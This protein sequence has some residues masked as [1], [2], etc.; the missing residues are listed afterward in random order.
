MK[1]RFYARRE[2]VGGEV[3]SFGKKTIYIFLSEK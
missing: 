2:G 1:K 3:A